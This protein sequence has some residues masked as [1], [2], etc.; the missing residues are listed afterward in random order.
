MFL[1]YGDMISDTPR[2]IHRIAEFIGHR[3]ADDEV[4]A[5]ARAVSFK[6]VKEQ[7]V[8]ESDANR[9]RP[10]AFEGGQATFINKGNNGRWRD[11]LSEKDLEMYRDTRDKV[12]TPDCAR[13]LEE[14]GEVN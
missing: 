9:D 4:E 12:L 10:D 5:V 6:R 13:W 8:A 2:E 14:G 1:H 11:V 3:M 7:A